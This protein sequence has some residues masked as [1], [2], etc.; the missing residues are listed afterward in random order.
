MKKPR[1]IPEPFVNDPE[2]RTFLE[3]VR[4]VLVDMDDGGKQRSV[5]IEELEEAGIAR[6]VDGKLTKM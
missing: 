3:E 1:A 2:L 5:T 4:N 6:L